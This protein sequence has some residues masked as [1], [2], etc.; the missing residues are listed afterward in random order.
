MNLS[1]HFFR[2]PICKCSLNYTLAWFFLLLG[3]LFVISIIIV[4]PL[5]LQYGENKNIIQFIFCTGGCFL[6]TIVSRCMCYKKNNGTEYIP[7]AETNEL[8]YK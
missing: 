7:F 2:S 4:N 6:V 1:D 3:Y 8:Y 5:E